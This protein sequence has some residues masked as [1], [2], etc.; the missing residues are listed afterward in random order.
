MRY[1]PMGRHV[2][3]RSLL[4]ALSSL[5]V[6]AAASDAYAEDVPIV[7]TRCART[8]AELDVTG[9]VLVGGVSKTATRH[10]R[11]LDVY[12]VLPDVT[13][14]HG[15]FSAPCDLMLRDASGAEKVLHDCSS[16]S[17]DAA[18]CAAM[19]PAV[20]FDGKTVVYAVYSGPLKIGGQNVAGVVIDPTASSDSPNTPTKYPNRYLTTKEARLYLIDVASGKVTPLPHVPGAIDN[21][22]TW[23]SD[24]RIGFASTRDG[25]RSTMV[26]GTN[27]PGLAS[28]LWAMDPDGKNQLLVSHH[29]L[30]MEE[31]PFTLADGRVVYS[32]W[33]IFGTLP[34]RYGNGS[35]GGFTTLSNLFHI[36]AQNPD[37]SHPFAF[38]GQHSG[39]HNTTTSIKM[40]HEAAHFL[41][42][43]SDGRVFFADYYRGNNNGLGG[44][45][46]VMP[47]PDGQEGLLPA[48]KIADYYAP[49]DAI[50]ASTW[51]HTGDHMSAAMPAP[52]LSVAG[53][54]DPMAFVGKLGHPGALPNNGL[55]V[56]WG[57]GPCSTVSGN[58]IFAKFG[59]T[60]PPGTSGSGSGTA[61][62]VVTS[63]GL[64]G[65]GCDAGIYR[66]SKV[67]STH[68]NDLVPI[69][70]HPEWH[71]IQA[72]ALVP[73]SAIHGIPAPKAIARADLRTSHPALPPGTPF[74][75]LG[76]ASMLDRETHPAAGIH[77]AGEH[78]F[79]LQGTDTIDYDDDSLC[80]LRILAIQ[81]N[82]A[83]DPNRTQRDLH[84]LTGE[85]VLILGEIPIR[86]DDGSGKPL[87]DASGNDD[88][89]FLVRF[90]A[91]TPY[92]MQGIDCEGRT[93]NTDQ[94]WQ[95]LKPGEQKT[96]GGCHVHSRPSRVEFP[97]TVAGQAGFS[98]ARLGEGTVPLL[99][100][101]SSL[102]PTTR[103]VPGQGL[104]IEYARDI[105][106][107][108]ERRCVSCHGG[109]KPAGS[110]ALDRPG[111][112][113]PKD[114]EPAS[115]W[116]CL[117][118]DRNQQC[119]PASQRMQTNAGTG[120]T[121][122]RPQVTRYIRALN[123]VASLLYWKAAG[124]RTDGRTDA[125][126]DENSPVADRDLDFGPA[127]PTTITPEELGLLSR[128]IDIGA[129]GGEGEL[130]DTTRPALNLAATAEGDAVTALHVG[131][132]DVPSGIDPASLEVCLVG[133]D[134]SCGPNLA[135][136][137]APNDVV[138]IAL[139]APLTDTNAEV[140]ATVK[141]LAGNDTTVQLSVRWLLNAPIPAPADPSA[142]GGDED[143]RDGAGAA[144]DDGGG[145]GCRAVA[146]SAES[147]CA[148]GVAVALLFG[149]TRRRRARAR[150]DP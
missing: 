97:T 84:D 107:I 37:G 40:D 54:K 103:T 101:G 4:G 65:P 17:S 112:D 137:A 129:P 46:G 9:T 109:A 42:Q 38:Y 86:H 77:F 149:V 14:F 35:V 95:S 111:L 127:H 45:V 51:G 27:N 80:G 115:T 13:H 68:P 139:A 100:G 10:M 52:P 78:Q 122:R 121:F 96:C 134:G 145:C 89:S 58:G 141:D 47:E 74:G 22:P 75:L 105:A 18:S 32:S 11:G 110:L 79:A 39:D 88:T 1:D 91:N 123:A 70:D 118:R 81:P 67:P 66:M 148:A 106:P 21:A 113:G 25:A 30:A 92:M 7:Y 48:D 128:W 64:D 69:V 73:Y 117:V 119:V 56:T 144:A 140:R 3:R 135:P 125:T 12:D 147:T 90:P 146:A 150:R 31:H 85:R 62:N 33:Q 136:A 34:F 124:K 44:V 133:P 72:R 41:T 130:M 5:V 15:G 6:L 50:N 102:A 36:Y 71:E 126:F 138:T 49:R 26:P 28:Q 120:T 99:A 114:A 87:K 60:A 2:V 94:T 29:G 116:W 142:A 59:K 20:S 8:T 104:Q 43:T 82:R 57:K 24:G 55:M 108:F 76:S 93:L 16:T 19:D 61:M 63:L 98:V 53:Y 132:S 131:T 143:S 23:L 83:E